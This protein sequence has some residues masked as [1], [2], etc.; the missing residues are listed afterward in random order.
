[1]PRAR[2]TTKQCS[3][4]KRYKQLEAFAFKNK[5]RGQ[6]DSRCKKCRQAYF[7]DRYKTSAARRESIKK[8]LRDYRRRNRRFVF[9]YLKSHPCVECGE[10][11]VILLEFDHKDGETKTA[12]V[13][14]LA[15]GSASLEQIKE[16][17]AKCKVLCVVCHRRKTAATLGWYA[18]L[19]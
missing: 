7:N 17:I 2:K 6:R 18:D 4:C 15:S 3:S 11:E 9:D 5:S 16:E 19:L 13:S 8:H 12:A 1:M 14:R 10:D